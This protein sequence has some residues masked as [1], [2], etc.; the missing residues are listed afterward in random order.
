MM[1][2][3]CPLAFHVWAAPKALLGPHHP[4]AR[5]SLGT[6]ALG[7]LL[8]HCGTFLPYLVGQVRGLLP[9]LLQTAQH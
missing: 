3:H 7:L 9:P 5:V 6:F 8:A 4:A 1:W 2:V